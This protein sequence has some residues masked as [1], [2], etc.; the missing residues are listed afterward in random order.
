MLEVVHVASRGH[1][2]AILGLPLLGNARVDEISR[3]LHHKLALLERSG[4]DDPAPLGT[5]IADLC[6]KTRRTKSVILSVLVLKSTN[7]VL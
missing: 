6:G 4:R 1:V 7:V 2:V 5:E 3:V